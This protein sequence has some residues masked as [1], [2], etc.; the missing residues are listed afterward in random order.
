MTDPTIQRFAS[1]S[2]YVNGSAEDL[3]AEVQVKPEEG[4]DYKQLLASAG[5]LLAKYREEDGKTFG[6]DVVLA[7]PHSR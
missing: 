7:Q 3:A 1:A 2:Y 4:G 6:E 5:T